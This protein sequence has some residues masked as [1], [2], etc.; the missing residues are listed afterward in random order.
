MAGQYRFKDI[1]GNI[2]AQISASAAGAISFSGSA[3]DF[4]NASTITLGE[5]QLAGTASNALL[6]DG[7]DSTAFVFTSS[8]NTISSSVSSQL[9]T[10]QTTSGSNIGRLNNLESKSSSVDISISN[11]NSVTASNIARLTNLETKSASVDISVS[12]INTFTS[13]NGNTSLNSK[14]G[15]Y[16]TTGSNTFFGTQTFSGSVYIANDLVVQGSSSIQYISASSVS[17]GTNIVQLNTAT[18][19]VRYAGLA[20][21]DSGSS[22]GITGSILWDSLCNRWMYSNPST[23]G[24]SGGIIMSGP[25]AATLGQ[26]T[27]LTCNYIAKSGAGDHLYDSCIWEMSGSV[28]INTNSPSGKF[29]VMDDSGSFFFD[30]S[31]PTYNR[32]KSTTTSSGT[33]RNLQFSTQDIGTTPDLFISGSGKIGMGTCTPRWQLELYCNTGATGAGQYPGI[34]INNACTSGY[35]GVYFYNG[36]NQIG[37]VEVSNSTGNILV[38][39]G[40]TLS[41]QTASNNRISIAN[42]GAVT[43][44]CQLY[45][46]GCNRDTVF[47]KSN[48]NTFSRLF[49]AGQNSIVF[50][51]GGTTAC[52]GNWGLNNYEDTAALF[53]V[54]NNGTTNFYGRVCMC[55]LQ[56]L[57]I[58]SCC[59]GSIRLGGEN[60]TGNS[61]LFFESNGNNS[62]IDNYGDS[63]YKKLSIEASCLILNGVSGGRVGIGTGTIS[64]TLHIL[65]LNDN[66]LKIDVAAGCSYSSINFA[67]NNTNVGAIAYAHNANEFQVPYTNCSCAYVAIYTGAGKVVTI[68]KSGFANFTCNIFAPGTPIQVVTG[69]ATVSSGAAGSGYS[70]G[71]NSTGGATPLYNQGLN[72]AQTTFTPKSASSKILIMTN[73]VVMWERSNVSDHFY[74]WAANHT[75][76]TILVKSGQY[77]QNFGPGGQNGGIIN[78]NGAASSWGT[79]TKTII[80]RI[81]TTGSDAGYYEWNPYYGAGGFNA[82]TVG[83]F[84]WTIMEIAQ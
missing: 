6:L 80:F 41:L 16:A 28:G 62:Y 12:S 25:R 73:S 64:S 38:N 69:N 58:G 29:Q 72:I 53:R 18:P 20:V 32:F 35:S 21:Q 71:T 40:T 82:D 56:I 1:N 45:L 24:Y 70:M 46:D 9:T 74:L 4:S 8:F 65:G 19:S 39:G 36:I 66:Q 42:T 34:S 79:S 63:E 54:F 11:I 48:N 15:S 50:H 55:N 30:G 22:A 31:L 14:T 81:G 47:V 49:Y 33:G 13:S 83:N 60:G 61:R 17:I 23:I 52:G 84:T 26:E 2:V 37:G 44:S 43:I 27:T 5:V 59:Q 68:D 77:L 67:R 76:G 78:L 3:V 57:S 7:F 10:L 75:D 51:N